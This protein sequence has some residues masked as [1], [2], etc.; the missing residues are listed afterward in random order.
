MM[1]N[2]EMNN[3]IIEKIKKCKLLIFDFDGVMTD[4]RVLVFQDGT[5]AVFCNRSDGLAI[6]MLN[7]AGYK[8][9]IL[10]TET[11]LVV[12]ARASKLNLEVIH[13]T[14]DKLT[15][16]TLYCKSNQIPM[17]AVC[18]VG[19]DINDLEVMNAVGIKIAPSDA[20]SRILNIADIITK[21]KGGSGVIRELTDII[22]G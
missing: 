3:L 18:Y 10:S 22:K 21:A 19:N 15:T 5:E 20:Y 16:L 1:G 11:N 14:E 17:E 7:A 12:K 13:G 4:N 8:M 6:E 9:L 2:F